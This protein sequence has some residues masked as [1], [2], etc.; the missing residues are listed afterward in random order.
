M[1]A[2]PMGSTDAFTWR[3][4]RDPALRSTVVVV[5]WLDSVPEWK[6]FE[7]RIDRMTRLMP[8]LRQR[9]VE[10]GVP[11]ATPR[12]VYD[13]DFDLGWHLR[14]VVAPPPRTSEVVLSMARQAVMDA[15]DK[16]RPLW[17]FT[18]VEGVEGPGGAEA[19]LILKVHHSLSDGV[20]GMQM[21]EVL[22]DLQR[23]PGEVAPMPEAPHAERLDRRELARGS[24]EGLATGLTRTLA[25]G[26]GVASRATVRAA[27]RPVGT[28]RD[29]AALAAS[30]YRTAGPLSDTLSP[31]M[32]ERATTRHVATLEIPL[33]VLKQ[34]ARASD[35]SVNAAYLTALTGGLRRY[36]ERHGTPVDALRVTMPISLRTE[37]DDAWGNRITLQRLTLPVVDP[38]PASRMR[39]IYAI[40]EGARHERSLPITGPIA[41]VLNVL[42]AGYVGGV[43]KHVDFLA[44][45]VQGS[46]V[47]LYL[48]GA[49][50]LGFFTFGPTIGAAFNATL[51]S[52]VERCDI[53]VT[54][55]TA[56]VPD[57]E[58]LV[59]CL[60]EGLAEVASLAGTRR[61]PA[62]TMRQA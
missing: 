15:F 55:D 14:R 34:A 57:P 42:P 50:V 43:L 48:A 2:T 18:L 10:P 44:S 32:K 17:E 41:G 5:L 47:P 46:P 39:A 62:R 52:H 59:Q 56:A 30:V 54:I 35:A 27:F 20:G 51:L 29:A 7:E 19:A 40:T 21:L 13:A 28:A 45:D 53:G 16:D 4:E 12:W 37:S 23:N 22:F 60:D 36:H 3:M 6:V 38:D 31:V 1:T 61:R 25:R 26:V 8:S 33:A 58:V 24:V 49:E 9:V 11:L